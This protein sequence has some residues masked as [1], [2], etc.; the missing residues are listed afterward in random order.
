MNLLQYLREGG[1]FSSGLVWFGI[2][3]PS[4]QP[5][6]IALSIVLFAPWDL[7]MRGISV[8]CYQVVTSVAGI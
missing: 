4:L 6:N 8:E 3:T 5:Y 7:N 2:W 1:K